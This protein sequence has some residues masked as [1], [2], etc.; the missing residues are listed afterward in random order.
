[1]TSVCTTTKDARVGVVLQEYISLQGF[2]PTEVISPNG[3]LFHLGMHLIFP[4]SQTNTCC[5]TLTHHSHFCVPKLSVLSSANVLFF[6]FFSLFLSFSLLCPFTRQPPPTHRTILFFSFL[7]LVSY[8]LQGMTPRSC[9][10][11]IANHIAC[12]NFC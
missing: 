1:M 2:V 6:L 3:R 7:T 8:S 10:F 5:L 12:L 11:S 9:C 4:S